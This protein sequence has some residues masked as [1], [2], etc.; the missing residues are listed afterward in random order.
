MLRR[1][2]K[3]MTGGKPCKDSRHLVK[4]FSNVHGFQSA[5]YCDEEA[6]K[7][8]VGPV[9]GLANA[10]GLLCPLPLKS[11]VKGFRKYCFRCLMLPSKSKTKKLLAQQQEHSQY[12][13]SPSAL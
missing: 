12:K 7:E 1:L 10:I 6:L 8:L 4:C 13:Y 5:A 11:V 9:H 2:F 3:S